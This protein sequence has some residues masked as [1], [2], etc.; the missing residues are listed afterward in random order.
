MTLRGA[1]EEEEFYR[2]LQVVS[3][4]QGPAGN[5]VR[6]ALQAALE[7][8]DRDSAVRAYKGLGS[9]SWAANR[10]H[11]ISPQRSPLRCGAKSWPP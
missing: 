5:V 8:L 1:L 3:D 10:P 4:H 2:Q 11:Q 7:I 9:K 6:A